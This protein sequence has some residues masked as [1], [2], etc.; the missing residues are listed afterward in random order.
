MSD[1]PQ[2]LRS[3]FTD[4][5]NGIVVPIIQRDYAQGRPTEYEVRER[6]LRALRDALVRS[7][8]DVKDPLDLDFV[9]GYQPGNSRHFIPIDGQQ[10]LT[11]L[12]LLHWYLAT[13]DHER[14]H[15]R[16][17]AIDGE[18]SR[19]K[20]EVR[21]S[22]EDFFNGLIQAYVDLDSLLPSDSGNNNSLSK[23][24]RNEPWFFLSWDLDPTVRSCLTMLDAIHCQFHERRGLYRRLVNNDRPAI[25]FRFLNLRKFGLGD[26]L[27][28]KMNARGRALTKFEE[29]KSELEGFIR[30]NPQLADQRHPRTKL[31]FYEHVGHQFDTVWTNLF[32]KLIRDEQQQSLESADSQWT[33]S[34]DPQMFNVVRSIALTVYEPFDITGNQTKRSEQALEDLHNGVVTSFQGYL[35]N[36]A[37][38]ERFV[39]ALMDLMDYWSDSDCGSSG[40]CEL[41]TWLP[42]RDYYDEDLM[43]Q[44]IRTDRPKRPNDNNK[45]KNTVTYRDHVRF[46]S[47]CSYLLSGK[48]RESGFDE[49]MRVISNLANNTPIE[50]G[51]QLRR[52][53]VSLR[54]LL[55]AGADSLLEHLA[56]GGEV[57]F[58]LKQQVREERLKAQLILRDDG[59]RQLIEMAEIHPYFLG[60]IEFVFAFSGLLDKWLPRERCTWSTNK[61][62]ELQQAFRETWQKVVLLFPVEGGGGLSPAPNFLWERALLSRGDYLLSAHSN[63]SL[64]INQHRDVSWKRLLRADLDDADRAAKRKLVWEVLSNLDPG[65]LEG[66]LQRVIDEGVQQTGDGSEEW[67]KVLVDHPEMLRYCQKRWMRWESDG[68]IYLLRLLQR[69]EHRGLHTWHLYLQLKPKVDAGVFQ[70][71]DH[72][73]LP[74]VWGRQQEPHVLL[75]STHNPELAF[76]ITYSGRKYNI[77]SI[78]ASKL[79]GPDDHV[80]IEAAPEDI[81]GSL[82]AL[83]SVH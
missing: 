4:E 61:D 39:R 19:F 52:A 20:Y 64:L 27:Y 41:R 13:L 15:F 49:W 28:I 82:M 24:L 9:Y 77:V 26:E 47:Y 73:E 2:T 50:S 32:W 80:T 12:F 68:R 5:W 18:R 46:A 16:S 6:F 70:P 62:Q 31:P 83:G 65:D 63:R 74:K 40:Q 14:Q 36:Q 71:L 60:Q 17:F 30:K 75:S 38:N 45:P 34:L 1:H 21:E 25:T 7:L 35:D 55:S 56:E 29:F 69:R 33:R 48:D 66:S 3:L 51:E 22:S 59:W 81:E 23:T 11:T 54:R 79:N 8:D 76:Q 78:D 67:R 42:R 58:F 44:T 72:V 10:R 37:A 43:F 57:D 53:L